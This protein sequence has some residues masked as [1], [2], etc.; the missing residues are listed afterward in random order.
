MSRAMQ[1]L[2]DDLDLKKTEVGTVTVNKKG[3]YEFVKQIYMSAKLIQK[4]QLKTGYKLE[5]TA[6]LSNN[7]HKDMLGWM[8]VD[9][10]SLEKEQEK[11]NKH[12]MIIK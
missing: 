9:V 7:K 6:V 11:Q 1:L 3:G 5:V 8:A 12:T 4:H 2:N 10:L